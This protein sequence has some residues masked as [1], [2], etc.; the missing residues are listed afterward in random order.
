M[1]FCIGIRVFRV[2]RDQLQRARARVLRGWTP[3]QAESL[4]QNPATDFADNTDALLV[5][6][7]VSSVSSVA[8]C[9]AV[10]RVLRGWFWE[11]GIGA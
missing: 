11:L 2:I 6:V 7:S 3:P 10:A 9:S 1:P 4:S 8:S 5:S